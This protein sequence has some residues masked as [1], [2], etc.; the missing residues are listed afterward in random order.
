MEVDQ[1][2]RFRLTFDFLC[3]V[4]IGRLRHLLKISEP[5]INSFVK[6]K[7][8]NSSPSLQPFETFRKLTMTSGFG[9]FTSLCVASNPV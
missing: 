3:A 8:N 4:K 7:L 5:P 9:C 1:F 6:V 2:S